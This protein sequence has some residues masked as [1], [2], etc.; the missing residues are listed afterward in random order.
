PTGA[1][2][3]SRGEEER[4]AARA[5]T[6]ARLGLDDA[7]VVGWVGSFRR[8][9][10]LDLAV[11]A[12][13]EVPGAALLLVGDGPER[14]RVEAEAAAR[15]VRT[16]TTGTV[17]HAELPDVL[18][19]MD[20]AV[21]V[22]ATGQTFHYSPLKLAEYLAAGLPVVA[23]AIGEPGARI[24]DGEDGL[25]VAPGDPAALA[26]ALRR[27]RD[28]PALRVRLG[29]RAREVAAE[30]WSWDRSAERVIAALGGR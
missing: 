1:D 29:T 14:R 4:A 17:P 27:L 5:A 18:A 2:P 15:G 9:H 26:A 25:L 19:A 24:R 13:A 21:V 23:P 3:E 8:F 11:A 30:S 28:D 16:V 7:F 6:R 22:A 10:A 20:A 12:V